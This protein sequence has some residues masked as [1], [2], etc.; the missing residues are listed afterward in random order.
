M[1]KKIERYYKNKRVLNG[2]NT[3]INIEPPHSFNTR[4]DF[5]NLFDYFQTARESRLVLG[6]TRVK[7]GSFVSCHGLD[8]D[9]IEGVSRYLPYLAA[10]LINKRH[11]EDYLAIK[12][13][14]KSTIINGV[15]YNSKGYWGEPLHYDQLICEMSDI[16]LSLWIARDHVWQEFTEEEKTSILDWLGLALNKNV[17][18]NN[19][20]LF[21]VVIDSVIAYFEK[22]NIRTTE[23]LDEVLSWHVK[24]G[25]FLDGKNGN[26]DYYTCWGIIYSLYW[27][28]QIK[29]ELKL[30]EIKDIVKS[31]AE[32]L[33]FMLTEEQVAPLFGR[34]VCYRLAAICPIII[35]SHL[36][37]TAINKAKASDVMYKNI[38]YF[39]KNGLFYEGRIS[40][41]VFEENLKFVDDYTGPFSSFWSLRTLVLSEYLYNIGIDLYS[42]SGDKLPINYSEKTEHLFIVDKNKISVKKESYKSGFKDNVRNVIY[43]FLKLRI[44]RNTKHRESNNKLISIDNEFYRK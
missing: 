26:I 7:D 12:E 32:S 21:L 28:N 1:L 13:L 43:N 39:S 34:S 4:E 37:E 2:K 42:H 8:M 40:A 17:S 38:N 25:W 41:G 11:H 6:N 19:W 31:N 18:R 36:Y 5:F 9:C 24:D 15:S 35:N 29:P 27:I 10:N 44:K 33:S 30:Q 3:E 20:L 16:A 23:L 14:F 22:R